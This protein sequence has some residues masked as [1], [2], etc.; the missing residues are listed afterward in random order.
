M[1]KI[2][3][4]IALF[5]IV[6]IGVSGCQQQTPMTKENAIALCREACQDALSNNLNL[7]IGPCLL[8]PIEGSDYV[9]DIAHNPREDADNLRENQCNAWHSGEARHFI[10]FTPECEFIKAV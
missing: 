3:L 1:K 2:F 10:E 9:C 4:I 5:A 8:D 7:S 6:A